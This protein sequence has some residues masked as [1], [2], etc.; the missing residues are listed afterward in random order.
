MKKAKLYI[1]IAVVVA[2]L[3]I[4]LV[5]VSSKKQREQKAIN[6]NADRADDLGLNTDKLVGD[7]RKIHDKLPYEW[8]AIYYTFGPVKDVILQYDAQ[9]FQVLADVYQNMF[10]KNLT[11]DLIEFFDPDDLAEVAEITMII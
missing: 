1:I 5:R 2:I 6:R 7:A 9:S 4:I 8:W 3:L 10:G 11:R